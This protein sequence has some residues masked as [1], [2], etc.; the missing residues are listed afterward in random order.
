VEVDLGVGLSDRKKGDNMA[1]Q[2]GR[3][4]GLTGRVLMEALTEIQVMPGAKKE[5]Q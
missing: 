5:R 3:G 2:I 1:V 4:L